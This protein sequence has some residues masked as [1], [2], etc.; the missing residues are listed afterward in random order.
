MRYLMIVI[1]CVFVLTGCSASLF[2]NEIFE[3]KKVNVT[4][5][6]YA[7]A[8]MLIQQTKAFVTSDTVLQIGMLTDMQ[9]PD[10]T[11]AFARMIPSH[12]GARFV[13]LGYN[14]TAS[15]FQAMTGAPQEAMLS[16]GS[17]DNA[18]YQPPTRR[19]SSGGNIADQALI[20]GH[21]VVAKSGVLVNLRIIETSTGRVLAAYDYSLPLSGD[22]KEL[23]KTQ[24]DNKNRDS[25]LGLL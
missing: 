3:G 14:V 22:I 6:S 10:H 25:W 7:A 16:G 19:M 23:V 20:T 21:Y 17:Y 1:S 2:Q 4:E 24:G 18:V 5:V 15:S 12:I 9:R 8:D 13:Q 11:T